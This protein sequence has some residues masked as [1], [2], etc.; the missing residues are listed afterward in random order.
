MVLLSI[1]TIPFIAAILLLF[2]KHDEKANYVA[3]AASGI[4]LA[5]S[6]NIACN[7]AVNFDA[8]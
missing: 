1:L 2:V 6:F 7:G 4:A 5:L 8:A 3:I